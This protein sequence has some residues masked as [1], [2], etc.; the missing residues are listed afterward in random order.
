MDSGFD[1]GAYKAVMILLATAG[2]I[3]PVLMRFKISPILAYL[4]AGAV[5]GPHGLG[6]FAQLHFL[7]IGAQDHVGEIAEFGVVFLLFLIGLELSLERLLTMRRLVFGLG[8]LQVV[9]T[10]VSIGNIAVM[11]GV[12]PAAGLMIGAALALSSTAIVVE[13]L[14]G[15][16]RLASATGRA[17]FAILLFQDVSVVPI[18]FL[19]GILGGHK[20]GSIILDLLRALVQGSV[21]VV[22]IVVLGRKLFQPFFRL[23]AA[24]KNHELFIAATLFVVVGASLMSAAAGLSMAFG[25]FIAGLL[26]GET[27]YRRAIGAEIEPFKGLLLG[28][29]FFTVGMSLDFSAMLANPFLLLA[30]ALALIVGKAFILA[31]FGRMFKLSWLTG[32]KTGLILGSGGEFGF[33]VLNE[34]LSERLITPGSA[35]FVLS[36]ITLTMAA[37]PLS[38]W[39]GQ[40]LNRRFNPPTPAPELTLI[41]PEDGDIRA[42]IIG[43]GRVGQ[44][45]GALMGVHKVKFIATDR[46]PKIVTKWRRAGE[47]I[48][49][50]DARQGHFLRHCH[51]ETASALIITIHTPD[52]IDA[53]VAAARVIR[54]DLVIVSRAQDSH[55]ASHLYEIGVTDAVPETIEA[56]LQLSEAAL[57]G[58]GVPAGYVIASIHEKRDEVRRQLQGAAAKV[59]R[60]SRG[61]KASR[62]TPKP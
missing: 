6:T 23:V 62:F 14:A 19:V 13:L 50:G 30:A 15:Q 45:V 29:F 12:T 48:Y 61:I 31:L 4:L 27:E 42:V 39:I 32:I 3:V 20:D 38:D 44:M 51:I 33:V 26:L 36:L 43:Y 22:V 7:T 35:S 47:P 49:F 10:A 24:S 57:V 40:W 59:G 18:L 25:A 46:D 11:F 56:S 41:P 28:I 21:T 54:P 52:E 5:L 9:V 2:L 8:T 16:R 53:I 34:A 60:V 58:L 55:H 1:F 37:I 17:S